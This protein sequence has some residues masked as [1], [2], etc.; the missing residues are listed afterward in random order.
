M[1]DL[2]QLKTNNDQEEEKTHS[3]I[4]DS[5][6]VSETVS[7]NDSEEEKVEVITVT[8]ETKEN[9]SEQKNSEK[10]LLSQC[11]PV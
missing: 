2:T 7:L 3:E 9:V 5:K 10:D 8:N 11:V 4:I 1:L 6:N